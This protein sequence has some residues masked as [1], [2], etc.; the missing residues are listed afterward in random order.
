MK[1]WVS[2]GLDPDDFWTK[3]PRY[4]GLI[5]EGKA[6]Q[7]RREHNERAWLA[8]HTAG[9]PRVKKFPA[10]KK[11]TVRE[12]HAP[13]SVDQQWAILSAMAKASKVLN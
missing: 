6:A 7:L 3:T 9:L 13:Q 10:L 5:F 2:L 4:I 1:Q 12:S 11:L 8:W